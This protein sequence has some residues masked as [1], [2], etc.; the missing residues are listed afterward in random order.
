MVSRVILKNKIDFNNS[1]K[2]K[3]NKNNNLYSLE[4]LSPGMEAESLLIKEAKPI[5]T[6]SK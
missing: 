2:F 4:W 1:T 3:K 6:I 5:V